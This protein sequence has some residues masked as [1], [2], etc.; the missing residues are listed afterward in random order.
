[1]L[2]V[3]DDRVHDLIH[4]GALIDIFC[5]ARQCRTD[6]IGALARCAKSARPSRF[7]PL[8]ERFFDIFG[9]VRKLLGKVI[10]VEPVSSRQRRNQGW[11]SIGRGGN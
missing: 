3:I 8:D 4:Q 6:S 9:G 2:H 7:G 10:A 5:Q 11:G 1:M